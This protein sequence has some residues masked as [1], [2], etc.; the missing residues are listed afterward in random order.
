METVAILL[1]KQVFLFTFRKLRSSNP[2]KQKA[3][4]RKQKVKGKKKTTASE[5]SENNHSFRP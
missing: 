1:L 5:D 4:L 3:K 2:G